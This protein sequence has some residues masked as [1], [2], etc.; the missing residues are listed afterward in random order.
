M[1]V[2]LL[3]QEIAALQQTTARQIAQQ[4]ET[5]ATTKKDMEGLLKLITSCQN[6]LF[7]E[8]DRGEKLEGDL[9][10]T[11][12]TEAALTKHLDDMN[13]AENEWKKDFVAS[14]LKLEAKTTNAITEQE[15]M[16]SDLDTM[17]EYLTAQKIE[18]LRDEAEAI[19]KSIEKPAPPKAPATDRESLI[20]ELRPSLFP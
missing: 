1:Q 4:D 2:R 13:T 8:Q 18:E 12:E 19:K 9:Q 3:G 17:K 14:L 11:R 16:G 7:R 5:L 6:D 10:K 20:R 15:K